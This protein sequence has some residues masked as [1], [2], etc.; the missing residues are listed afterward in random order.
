ML[1]NNP[2]PRTLT[3][4]ELRYTCCSDAKLLIVHAD[5]QPHRLNIT[6]SLLSKATRLL[7]LE[8]QQY[9]N[10]TTGQP[11]EPVNTSDTIVENPTEDSTLAAT[12]N[13]L[14]T[15]DYPERLNVV[16]SLLAA[17]TEAYNE[18]LKHYQQIYNHER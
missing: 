10:Y 17:A 3:L 14:K 11:Y 9:I 18:A 12:I 16:R 5:Q 8:T 4:N 15:E 6:T 7:Q 1:T 13:V 2:A